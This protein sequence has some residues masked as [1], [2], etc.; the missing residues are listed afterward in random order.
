ML[1]DIVKKLNKDRAK[2]VTPLQKELAAIDK[3]L[4]SIENQ[5]KRFFKLFE[6]GNVDD[7]LFVDRLTEL[8]VQ[9]EQL[10]RRN[11]EAER[12]LADSTSDPVPLQQV[13]KALTKFQRLLAESP[14][15][16]QKTLPQTVVKQIHVKDGRKVEGIEIELAPT[17]HKHF[18]NSPLPPKRR[19]GLLLFASKSPPPGTA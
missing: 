3:E 12:Q 15:E 11:A 6:A 9:H 5:R 4:A 17:V 13:R 16:T 7:D 14:P 10:A 19:R 8:K 18:L 2:S 1:E